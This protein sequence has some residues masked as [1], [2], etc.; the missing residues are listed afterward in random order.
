MPDVP[1][2][3]IV[4]DDLSLVQALTLAVETV[5]LPVE[6]CTSAETAIELLKARN[7]GCVVLDLILA[8]GLSGMYVVEAARS[9]P[10]EKRPSFVMMTGANVEQMRGVGRDVVKAILL[11]PLDLELFAQYV[12]ATY[13]RALDLKSA[14]GAVTEVPAV[15]A[16]CGG[17]GNELPSW[18][19]GTDNIFDQWL[20]MPCTNCG[21]TPR[22]I[23]P[24][25]TV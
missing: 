24:G 12:L 6:Y 2:V 8:T 18:I 13:R 9:L 16:Y 15:R 17:C 3:L 10:P 1:P 23:S 25:S 7:Y 19:A 20:D 21:K 14:A 5:G 22:G 11:K 4:E